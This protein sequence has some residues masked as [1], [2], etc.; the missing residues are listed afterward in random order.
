MLPIVM[1]AWGEEKQTKEHKKRVQTSQPRTEERCRPSNTRPPNINNAIL[2]GE[3]IWSDFSDTEK[4]FLDEL[5]S[6][7]IQRL[8]HEND[9]AF[10]WS[11]NMKSANGSAVANPYHLMRTCDVR[12]AAEHVQRLQTLMLQA[13]QLCTACVG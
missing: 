9:E 12:S 3:R 8:Q 13:Q 10:G 2:R 7:K 6:G 4:I 11:R 1:D 5:N